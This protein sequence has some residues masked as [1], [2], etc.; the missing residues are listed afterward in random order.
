[1]EAK[2][3]RSRKMFACWGNKGERGV[4]LNH[5]QSVYKE[6]P[7]IHEEDNFIRSR[8]HQSICVFIKKFTLAAILWLIICNPMLAMVSFS[9]GSSIYLFFKKILCPGKYV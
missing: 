9:Q 3:T 6:L 2:P 1:M 4:M 8:I 5:F 7:V